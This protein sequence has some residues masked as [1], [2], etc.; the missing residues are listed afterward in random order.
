MTKKLT[1][2]IDGDFLKD[3]RIYVDGE[4]LPLEDALKIIDSDWIDAGN[5]CDQTVL[6]LANALKFLITKNR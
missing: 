1:I 2:H 6:D 5:Y 3:I 4:N